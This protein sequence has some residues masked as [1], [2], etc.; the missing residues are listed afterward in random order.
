MKIQINT[1]NNATASEEL[2]NSLME[3]I[4]EPLKRFDNQISRVE[5]HLSDE[6]GSKDG[7][8]DKRCLLEARLEG[9]QPL[10]VSE[11]ADTYEKAVKGAVDK[12]K[13]SLSTMLGRLRNY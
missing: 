3:L 10:A 9:L 4:S 12:M 11:Q 2:R 7:H 6:D 5:V 1:D 13:T 8:E